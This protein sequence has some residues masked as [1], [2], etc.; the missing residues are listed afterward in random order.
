MDVY[1]ANRPEGIPAT[2]GFFKDIAEAV[3]ER[4]CF[5]SVCDGVD[6]VHPRMLSGT[7][8]V[9]LL[10]RSG[11]ATDAEAVAWMDAF[12]AAFPARVLAAVPAAVELRWIRP[13]APESGPL[14]DGSF[15]RSSWGF[16]LMSV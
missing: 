15:R 4:P 6:W 1:V 14:Q 11:D 13:Q 10:V 8:N 7:L 5:V 12:V 3:K 16:R 2:V 9:E